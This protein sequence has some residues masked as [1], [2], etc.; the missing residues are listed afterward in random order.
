MTAESHDT[1]RYITENR[2]RPKAQIDGSSSSL[3][4]K[5]IR[6][7]R[8]SST[9]LVITGRSLAV[10]PNAL[11]ACRITRARLNSAHEGWQ[12]SV[13]NCG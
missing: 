7:K 4:Y 9:Y 12:V 5:E 11:T 1:C 13:T 2:A 8:T 6:R 10:A 3:T